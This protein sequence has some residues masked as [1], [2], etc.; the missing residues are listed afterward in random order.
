MATIEPTLPVSH[1]PRPG[2]PYR[3]DPVLR[4]GPAVLGSV[5]ALYGAR[6]RDMGGVV[7]AAVGGALAYGSFS[8]PTRR[9][10]VHVRQAYTI[11]RPREELFA[12]WRNFEN[13]PRFMRHLE[14]VRIIDDR[15]SHWVAC[16]PG[17]HLVEWQAEITQEVPGELIAW[18][19]LHGS[20]IV[21]AGYV[22]FADAPGGRGTELYVSLEYSPPAGVIGAAVAK[23]FGADPEFQIREDLRSLR[24][25]IETGEI[26]TTKGQPSGRRGLMKD[27]DR[28]MKKMRDAAAAVQTIT[29][30]GGA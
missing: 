22:R 16:G 4:W 13:L 14:N 3:T 10:A 7:L 28:T 2:E 17:N 5:L 12:F 21:H 11:G 26:P 30:G 15:R 9:A 19:S 20:E 6:R 27:P 8:H 18:R 23:L 1:I 25:F 29:T 24:R